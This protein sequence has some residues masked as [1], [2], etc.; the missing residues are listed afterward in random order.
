LAFL[1]CRDLLLRLFEIGLEVCET[2][3]VARRQHSPVRDPEDKNLGLEGIRFVREVGLSA[4]S[5]NFCTSAAI[6]SPS[7]N[8]RLRPASIC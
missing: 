3:R 1:K 2:L 5:T 6:W 8:S 7:V 4:A